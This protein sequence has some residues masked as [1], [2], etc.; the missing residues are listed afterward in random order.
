MSSRLT[1]WLVL[2]AA[3]L[4][5]SNAQAA[6]RA[7]VT[8][9]D[10]ARYAD[11]GAWGAVRE[12]NLAA[13]SAHV[14]FLASR[15]LAPGQTLKLDFLDI[16]L[17]GDARPWRGSGF[18]VRVL[19]G[20]A[21]WPRL[22]LRYSLQGTGGGTQAGTESISDLNYLGRLGGRSGSET[23][24]HEKRLLDDWFLARFVAGKSG[25]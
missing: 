19:R 11:A 6:G 16:D 3:G 17:A 13:L 2:I 5:A 21:D 22:T 20:R 10:A 8:F 4:A 9:V 24:A 25:G 18:D 15:H 12:A 23:L 14:Q 7:E 1:R